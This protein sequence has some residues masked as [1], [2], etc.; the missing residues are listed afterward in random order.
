MSKDKRIRINK[1]MMAWSNGQ[2]TN[3]IPSVWHQVDDYGKTMCDYHRRLEEGYLVNAGPCTVVR[4]EAACREYEAD[5][6]WEQGHHLEA[7]QQMIYAAS[8]VLPD[9]SVSFEFED[10]QWLNPEEQLFWHP[11]LVEFRRLMRRCREYCKREPRLW[12]VL[13][14]NR[15]YQDYLKYLANLGA[16][17][18]DCK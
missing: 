2:R 10:T 18:H 12:P 13:E 8:S 16:W 1:R 15:T 14:G 5:R 11:N 7:L 17:A 4:E 3:V 9:E 6:S